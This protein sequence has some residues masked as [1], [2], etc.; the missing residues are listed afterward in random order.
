MKRIFS[1][2]WVFPI[3]LAVAGV[4]LIAVGQLD[5]DSGRQAASLPPIPTASPVA[6]ATASPQPSTSTEPSVPAS[7]EA[8]VEP[9]FSPLPS[10]VIAKQIEIE[11]IKI[12]IAVRQSQTAETDDFP[13]HDAAYI[14]SGSSQPGR[15]TNSYIFAHAE[16]TLFKPLWNA[17]LGNKVRIWMS[18]GS[19]L[20]YVV[21]EVR[22]NVSCPDERADPHPNPPLALQYAPNNCEEG[23]AWM[24][25]A[26]PE[27]LTLQTSQGYN[28]N[29]GELV[30]IA[31]PAS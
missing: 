26:G 25:S 12:N 22:P 28:R 5:L 21:T 1:S 24:N 4:A 16:N 7:A 9:S 30:V 15:G 8:S 23:V 19:V 18:D 2:G 11:A 3:V 29:W 10:D 27:R 6:A 20:E 17:Q 14:L 31:E 13:P